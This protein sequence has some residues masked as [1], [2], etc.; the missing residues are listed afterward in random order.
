MD[1]KVLIAFYKH[2]RNESNINLIDS[3]QV[4]G[5]LTLL[6]VQYMSIEISCLEKKFPGF[7]K[8]LIEI[9]SFCLFRTE[10]ET[11]YKVRF[12]F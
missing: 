1:E 5:K 6:L 4:E 9:K 8:L 10:Y 11:T 12:Y 7:S 2:K 3:K